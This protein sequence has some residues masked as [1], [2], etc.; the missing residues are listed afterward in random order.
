MTKPEPEA[1]DDGRA[2]DTAQPLSPEDATLLRTRI[3]AYYRR[4]DE[5]IE[6]NGWMVQGVFGGDTEPP[7]NYT[8]GMLGLFGYELLLVGLDLQ[9]AGEIFNG[10]G[11][12]FRAGKRLQSGERIDS[13]RWIRGNFP[14]QAVACDPAHPEL[15][16]K[17]LVQ[18]AR[19]HG[20]EGFPVFQLLLSDQNGRL[21]DEPGFDA[22]YMG[23]RQ[24]R[25]D[26]Q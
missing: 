19:R 21:P 2:I 25:F 12:D 26:K 3:A 6:R 17:Y 18:A 13:S 4:M 10:L 15:Y 1:P 22:V 23:P 7:F 11:A 20:R 24:P 5:A 16:D 8:I 9:L 14:L